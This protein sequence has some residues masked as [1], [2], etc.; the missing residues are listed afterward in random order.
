M[1][2]RAGEWREATSGVGNGVMQANVVILPK[3][4]ADDFLIYCQ[5]NPISCPL[6]AVSKPGSCLL[7]QLG[8]NIDIRSDIPEYNIYR[9]IY[10]ILG[11]LSEYQYSSQAALTGMNR[12]L[13]QQVMD[14]ISGCFDNR[15]KNHLPILWAK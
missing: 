1:K 15:S 12:A 5:N 2:I 7:E 10:C 3:E 13:K 11:Y 4:W 14:M 6:L 9:G 8:T